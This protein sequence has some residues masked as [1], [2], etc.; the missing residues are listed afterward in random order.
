MQI[1]LFFGLKREKIHVFTLYLSHELATTY[2]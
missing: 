2:Q 1:M